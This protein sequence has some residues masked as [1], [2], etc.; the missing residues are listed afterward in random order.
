MCRALCYILGNSSDKE[1]EWSLIS[2][3]LLF[4]VYLH[5]LSRVLGA[6]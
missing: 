5:V 4:R 2:Q 6:R 1:T 3:S